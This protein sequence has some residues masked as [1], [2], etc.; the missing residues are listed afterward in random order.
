M[1]QEHQQHLKQLV[2]CGMHEHLS[3]EEIVE[4]DD[5]WKNIPLT[6]SSVIYDKKT[7]DSVN[8]YIGYRKTKS[9]SRRRK[10]STSS[11]RS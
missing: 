10:R 7:I 11:F 9:R 6:S 5:M 2:E 3:L 8:K 4:Q 1:E